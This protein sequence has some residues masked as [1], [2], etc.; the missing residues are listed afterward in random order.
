MI[1]FSRG[2]WPKLAKSPNESPRYPRAVFA[3]LELRL[4]VIS[5]YNFWVSALDN[6]PVIENDAW[7]PELRKMAWGTLVTYFGFELASG[8]TS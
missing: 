7:V 6:G 3:G 2:E 8:A 5:K 4:F 1:G